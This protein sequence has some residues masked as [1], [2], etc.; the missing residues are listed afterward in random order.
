MILRDIEGIGEITVRG[1][2]INN[3]R[4]A[5]DTVFVAEIEKEL[6]EIL[7]VGVTSRPSEANG[8]TLNNKKTVSMVFTTESGVPN[9]VLRVHSEVIQQELRA[10]CI[11]RKRTNIRREERQGG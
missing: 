5:D 4:F 9:C 11:L 1:R 3:V 7:D 2:N 6:Q 8:L 10:L